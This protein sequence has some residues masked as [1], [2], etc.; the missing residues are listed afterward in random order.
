M[1]VGQQFFKVDSL[2][3]KNFEKLEILS[4]LLKAEI[5]TR[6][7]FISFKLKKYF[8]LL[9]NKPNYDKISYEVLKKNI[10]Y[11]INSR[12][13]IDNLIFY[14]FDKYRTVEIDDAI[15]FRRID[16]G[17]EIF[18]AVADLSEIWNIHMDKFVFEFPQSLYTLDGKYYMLPINFI[19][20]LSLLKN[21]KRT[22]FLFRFLFNKDF[23]LK[24]NDF[25]P[26]I[27]SVKENLSYN[28]A[29]KIVKEND[30]LEKISKNLLLRRLSKGAIVLSDNKGMK[31][32][33]QELMILVNYVTA[34]LL[35]Q[36]N[37]GFISRVFEL[38]KDFD[39]Y[40][41]KVYNDN[42][43]IKFKIL[44][45]LSFARYEVGCYPHELLGLDIYL[46]ITS[47]IR[48]YVDVVNQ[49]QLLSLYYSCDEFFNKNELREILKTLNPILQ[50]YNNLAKEYN[51]KLAIVKFIK[52][53]L[54]SPKEYFEFNYFV[55]NE[56]LFIIPKRIS[57]EVKIGEF[58]K[59]K[60][61]VNKESV[62]CFKKL[63]I[64]D[65]LYN[66][67]RRVN[68]SSGNEKQEKLK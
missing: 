20:E 51:K 59:L 60:N 4:V 47:P 33:I 43:I 55:N 11:C 31:L 62:I 54:N 68:L 36:N 24:K 29:C 15:S 13:F 5:F 16:E 57:Q 67:L 44:S 14:S 35:Q 56:D 2:S 53:L 18:V 25:Q 42:S 49:K 8:K 10:Q 38:P 26:C 46:H 48:R 32:I 61:K 50:K 27:I 39:S 41:G 30:Y 37:F 7:L 65:L 52:Y 34:K 64:V 45:M 23:E 1:S 6:L 63:E 22:V 9:V 66:Y 12:K 28:K 21:Q 40:K 3:I 19:K 58:K 17:Y